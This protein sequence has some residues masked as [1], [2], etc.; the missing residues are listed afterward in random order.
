M[1]VIGKQ[2][3]VVLGHRRVPL[4]MPF[5]S[6]AIVSSGG[7]LLL[8]A[9]TTI[10]WVRPQAWLGFSPSWFR[11][12]LLVAVLASVYWFRRW[13]A[14]AVLGDPV[15]KGFFLFV[16]MS[17]LWLP[18]AVNNFWV[19]QSTKTLATYLA[20]ATVP[21]SLFL[22]P[23]DRR[24]QFVKFWIA[25]HVYFSLYVVLHSG[26][27]PG[28]IFL[29]ENDMALT[30]LMC[31]PYPIFL[32]RRRGIT[33]AS[34]LF[35][36]GA[37]FTMLAGIVSTNS[38]GGFLGLACVL[39]YLC[40]QSRNKAR[41]FLILLFLGIV[42]LQFVPDSYVERIQTITDTED[43]SRN[44]RLVTWEIGW[45]MF[46][47]Y[48]LFGVGPTNYP[49]HAARYQVAMDDYVPGDAILAGRASHSL[50]FT[51][52][53][54][55]GLV[56]SAIFLVMMIAAIR[57]LRFCEE[58]V[59]A[60]SSCAPPDSDWDLLLTRALKASIIGYLTAGAFISV[61]YYPHLWFTLGFVVALG[62]SVES[63]YGPQLAASA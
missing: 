35:C 29:D 32:A 54:E 63:K 31:L 55:Y 37:A 24:L 61:L 45:N 59:A 19:L 7:F 5:Y 3:S 27:G 2:D 47:D 4:T 12:A 57:K 60:H 43:T 34:R 20:A 49:V 42:A 1:A 21:M 14:K 22:I 15:L 40:Y 36:Y 51:L 9:F 38:R 56:G 58:T 13:G 23:D 28:G 18:F 39:L 33:G 41:S 52:L 16:L 44:E 25:I 11:P 46:L 17:L 26:R 53:P 10:E 6:D 50:Y 30:L 48:P 8:L 62:R